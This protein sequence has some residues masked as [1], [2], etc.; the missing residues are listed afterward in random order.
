MPNPPAAFSILTIVKSIFRRSIVFSR[1]SLSARRPGFPTTSPTKRML[2]GIFHGASLT[3]HRHLDLARILELRLDLFRHVF[4]HPERLVV[5]DLRRLH[6]D[7]KLSSRLDGERLL[8][9]L[10]TV[11]DV[12]EFLQPLDVSLQNLAP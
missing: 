6:D 8:N 12:F 9:A 4:R 7:P 5:G 2:T 3:D 10:E 1:A 11:R